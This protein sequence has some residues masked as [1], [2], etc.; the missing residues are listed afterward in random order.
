MLG[1][2]VLLGH[3]RSDTTGEDPRQ[4]KPVISR[5]LQELTD[6]ELD[7]MAVY[8]FWLALADDSSARRLLE[9]VSRERGR[10]GLTRS[11]DAREAAS[12]V[13]W[14]AVAALEGAGPFKSQPK[15]RRL[16]RLIVAHTLET[17]EP[18]RQ[19]ALGQA[20]YGRIDFNHQALATEVRRLR[21][22]LADYYGRD[23]L[24]DPIRIRIPKGRYMAV[25]RQ[26]TPLARPAGLDC[27]SDDTPSNDPRPLNALP[28][29]S[30]FPT[31]SPDGHV[32]FAWNRGKGFRFRLYFQARDSLVPTELTSPRLTGDVCPAWSPDGRAL[33]FLRYGPLGGQVIVAD[34]S[35]QGT[36]GKERCLT[37]VTRFR[38]EMIGRHLTWL[39][40]GRGLLVSTIP[41]G[42]TA[43]AICRLGLEG[44]RSETLTTPPAGS[45]GDGDPA[46]S[47][48]GRAMAFV[49]TGAAGIK[50]VLVMDLASGQVISLTQDRK[51]VYGITWRRDGRSVVVA[52]A[53]GGAPALW[54]VPLSGETPSP[55]PIAA[56]KPHYPAISPIGQCLAFT[57]ATSHSSV[58]EVR[59][60]ARLPLGRRPRRLV[61]SARSDVN[62]HVSA[63]GRHLAF[64]S[65]RTGRFE[66]W[67]CSRDGSNAR[68]VSALPRGASAGTPRWSPDGRLIAF[69][70]R[71]AGQTRIELLELSTGLTRV[72]V[73]AVE[74][75]VTPSWSGDGRWVYFTSGRDGIR[76]ACRVSV[77]GGPVEALTPREGLNP[78]ESPD[79]RWLYFARGGEGLL[80]VSLTTGTEEPILPSLK[81]AFQGLWDVTPEALYYVDSAGD[82]EAECSVERLDLRTGQKRIVTKIPGMTSAHYQGLSVSADGKSL[83]FSRL[84]QARG[85]I[86]VVDLENSSWPSRGSIAERNV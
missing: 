86:L 10:R 28:G 16:L 65:D 27:L 54:D 43:F 15:M 17:L 11:T 56:D 3:A 45:L 85:E 24:A 13:V 40:D 5:D 62:P 82:G 50:D 23:G 30:L 53:R 12:R 78:L 4:R 41:F 39:P 52:S 76:P 38:S 36:L 71:M 22:V 37:R 64:A 20:H 80:R 31:F 42:Q 58:W 84:D 19:E 79:G 68:K 9:S 46:V 77:A 59:L 48:D 6:H 61:Y 25:I 66:I 75:A 57:S 63:D 81:S 35:P 26:M 21:E 44:L 73:G 67:V 29:L 47:P 1:R 33:A 51:H 69:D 32:V 18:I 74:G 83:V 60:D 49:R 7:E 70:S 72:L 14:P 34:V 55:V 8:G 2:R